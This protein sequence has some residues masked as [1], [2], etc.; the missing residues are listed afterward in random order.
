MNILITGGATGI[1]L[2]SARR[3]ASKG[4]QVLI[5]A[6]TKKQMDE[7][8]I[9]VG[10]YKNISVF[11]LDITD[12]EHRNKL[13]Y[14]NIDVLINNAAIGVGG[15]IS[16]VP[17]DRV[18][19]NFEVN[20]FSS[21]EVMQIVM[22]KM[23]KKGHGRIVLMSSILGHIPIKFLGVY[24]A[25]KSSISTLATTLNKELKMLDNDV[26][27]CLIEPGAYHTGFNQKMINN[28]FPWMEKGSYFKDDI[29]KLKK[30]EDKLFKMMEKKDLRSI[31]N[32]VEKAAL[33]D[34]PR[35]RYRA[36]VSQSFGTKLY[37]MF[38][39]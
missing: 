30:E 29:D 35:F 5:G 20:V 25:T 21:F 19:D 33:S 16:E 4:A 15:S 36:P 9:E 27:V 23:M 11:L 10:S 24:A 18:R 26:K 38:L 32:K 3:L 28:K 31:V 22:K 2:E 7:A 39:K 34:N 1:G 37:N 13:D 12:E 17:M 8:E 14:L 6:H